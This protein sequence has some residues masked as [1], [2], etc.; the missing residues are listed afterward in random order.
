MSPVL[1]LS[2]IVSMAGCAYYFK[3]QF[4]IYSVKADSLAGIKLEKEQPMRIP[5]A[6][7]LR[8]LRPPRVIPDFIVLAT[9]TL[10]W[11]EKVGQDDTQMGEAKRVEAIEELA[12]FYIKDGYLITEMNAFSHVSTTLTARLLAVYNALAIYNKPSR[13]VQQLKEVVRQ[14][15][16]E[17]SEVTFFEIMITFEDTLSAFPEVAINL[18][19]LVEELKISQ[20]EKISYFSAY[21]DRKLADRKT[22]LDDD[23][24]RSIGLALEKLRRQGLEETRIK[25]IVDSFIDKNADD[26][27][28]R[29]Q[30]ILLSNTYRSEPTDGEWLDSRVDE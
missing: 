30:A 11:L 16:V 15:L 1:V 2:L 20:E 27:K 18:L 28:L 13:N 4:A 19:S 24:E 5:R 9:A 21:L 22:A 17:N 12:R 29:Q 6:Q 8:V 25:K 23:R 26:P 10:K 14:V 7:P 3:E